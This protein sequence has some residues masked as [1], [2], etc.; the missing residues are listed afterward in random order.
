MRDKTTLRTEQTKAAH[1][2][3]IAEAY[4]RG[5]PQYQIAAQVGL[6]AAQVSRDLLVLQE[7]WQ[8]RAA[9]TMDTAKAA[10]LAKLDE[11]ERT[12]W[13]AWA[14]STQPQKRTKT[15]D[16]AGVKSAEV[17]SQTRDG[18]PAFLAGVLACLER[19]CKMLGIDAPERK[20][21]TSN[22]ETLKIYAGFDPEA[23]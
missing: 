17:G 23:V 19:R 11:L 10:E 20:D 14:A 21:V 9:A 6:S 12:Y 5:V 22:G 13:A 3:A 16:R 7:Q 18:N 8:V 15:A 4:L 1:R 2:A